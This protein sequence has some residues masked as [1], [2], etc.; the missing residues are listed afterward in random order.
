MKVLIATYPFGLCGTK[1]VD[2][3]NNTGWEIIYNSFGRRL[4]GNEVCEML[5]DVDGVIAGTEPYIKETIE[6]CKNLKVIARVGVGLDNVDYQACKDN[7]VVLTYTPEAPAEGVADLTIAQIINLFRGIFISDKS[8]KEGRWNRYL[9]YLL[10]E[11]KIGVLGVGRIGS[12]VI[13]RLK[14]FNVNPI[15]ACDLI[16]KKEIEDVIW[17]SKEELFKT[18]DLV[19]IH[20][21]MNKNNFHCVGMNE[22]SKMKEGSFII[23]TSRGLIVDE[24]E[25]ISLLYNKH[26]RGVALDVFEN[27]PDVGPL[28]D[29][30]NVI[31]TSHI[32]ASAH[33]SRYLMELGAVEDCIR[34]LKGKKPLNKVED[35]NIG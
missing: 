24:K 27:E 34:V 32:G 9:G 11:K 33:K 21:P 35:Q 29:F 15:Y 16:P 20:I 13:K 4:K 6:K 19:T 8:V 7:N 5:K 26:L 31:L 12:R 14:S 2:I 28:K 10:S 23:N 22:M 3:L 17:L 25:L 1:P 30:D 18:C